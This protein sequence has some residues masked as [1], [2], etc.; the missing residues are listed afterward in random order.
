MASRSS[1]EPPTERQ[2]EFRAA[3]AKMAA[4]DQ[5]LHLR[6]ATLNRMESHILGLRSAKHDKHGDLIPQ[7]L[8]TYLDATEEWLF[9]PEADDAGY[10]A[11]QEKW[12][13][14]QTK[15]SELSKEYN[16]AVESERKAKEAEMEAE[17]KQAQKER[18]GEEA[19]DEED[20]D[21]RRLPK[22]RRME[23]VMKNKKEGGELFSDGN[24][25]KLPFP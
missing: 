13:E 14:I 7:E 22:K 19:G 6:S 9:S 8:F 1:D 23:I 17:A 24:F 2:E 21:N 25:S 18:E 15:T 10:E 20:H 11:F 4:L 3:E 12:Q 16:E 5:E